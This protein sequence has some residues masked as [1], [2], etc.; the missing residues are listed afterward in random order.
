MNWIIKRDTKDEY[1]MH[2]GTKGQK[3]GERNYQNQ[4][5]SLTPA[6]KE[7]YKKNPIW[8]SQTGRGT[9]N[10]GVKSA[11]HDYL[12]RLASRA[13]DYAKL[14]E[15]IPDK[16]IDD[17]KEDDMIVYEYHDEQGR[18]KKKTAIAMD[19]MTNPLTPE[20]VHILSITG[21][22]GEQKYESEPKF[23]DREFTRI[24]MPAKSGKVSKEL[25]DKLSAN[26]ASEILRKQKPATD[27]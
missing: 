27:R 22:D 5:G 18:V 19:F 26:L 7:R 20:S 1:L 10:P 17:L 13:T 16:T 15:M 12:N 9:A 4:D 8:N 21:K 25:V 2:Y 23:K 14:A 6:G 11:N 3:W 24:V